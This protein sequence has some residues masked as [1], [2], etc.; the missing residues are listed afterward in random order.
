MHLYIKCI[1]LSKINKLTTLFI[2]GDFNSKLGQDWTN[3]NCSGHFGRG[4]RNKNGQQLVEFSETHELTATNTHFCHRASHR[5]TWTGHRKDATTGQTVP[6][7]NQIDFILVPKS[8]LSRVTNARSYSG[9]RLTSDHRL[10]V[11]SVTIP[12][13][14]KHTARRKLS[15]KMEKFNVFKL[16]SDKNER[17]KYQIELKNRI[18]SISTFSSVVEKWAALS[19]SI[20]ETARETIGT[21]KTRKTKKECP[22][23]E[24]LS[25]DQQKL[26]IQIANTTD[27]LAK[28]QLQKS[29]N[30]LL[31]QIHKRIETINDEEIERRTQNIESLKDSAQMF[32]SVRELTRNKS[33]PLVV[34]N[35]EGE[36]VAQ[37]EEAAEIVA[38][39]Y[40]SLFSSNQTPN[41][42]PNSTANLKKPLNR[43]IT[44][45]E[46]KEATNKLQNGRAVGP[47]GIPGELLKYGESAL[48][49]S[50]A[51]TFNQMFES[52][53]ELELGRGTLIVLPKP[54]KP[55]GLMSSLRPIVLLTTLRKTLSLITLRRIR[56]EVE[57]FLSKSQSGFRQYRSTSDA[58]WTHKWLIAIIMKTAKEIYILGLDMSRAFDT[59]DRQKL[60]NELR[61]IIDEDSWRMVKSLLENTNL[62][63][64]IGQ[65]LS[66][67]FNTDIGA[68][69]GDCLSPVLFVIYLELALRQIR[70]K[71]PRPEEDRAVP[72]EV[73]YADDTDFIS[74][75]KEVIAAIEPAAETIL[76]S[77]NLAVNREKT[78]HTKLNREETRERE[79]WRKTKKLGTLL[80]DYEEMKKRKQL[81][82][83]SFNNLWRIWSSKNNKI[84]LEKR[85]RLYNAYIIPVLTYNAC[86]WALTE[87]QLEELEAF[88]RK[89]LR[90]IIGI[91]YPRHISNSKLYEKCKAIELRNII[92]GARWRMSGHVLRMTDDTPAKC[93][94][95]HY[96]DTCN[97]S[98]GRPI[99]T[100]PTIINKDLEEAAARPHENYDQLGLPKKMSNIHDLRQL[101]TIANSRSKWKSIVENMHVPPPAKQIKQRPRRYEKQQ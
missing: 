59:I 35:S 1:N 41:L 60:L 99:T 5:T 36:I 7:Y 78:E 27:T 69:Q 4:R 32:Q 95:V 8:Q 80:G 97:K 17:I 20:K 18:E 23:L 42:D 73:L 21:I 11:T 10:V 31:I 50:I 100:M 62:Q 9:T 84:S 58:V 74:T 12:P 89:Q 86:T 75:S 24:K 64:R 44:I 19:E 28:S 54:G 2:A 22:L 65:T 48:H 71:C 94:T 3:T 66:K 67:P 51:D 43:P 68:P 14:H 72:N 34:K 70:A 76:K 39:H 92:R 79:V 63:A 25:V 85:L 98:R 52:G 30:K 57:S 38:K 15:P 53:D 91:E 45:E 77:W 83:V 55:P 56:P 61:E 82:T 101:E 88:R 46:V 93:A 81:A 37:Q 29:R 13:I 49:Q 40:V 96:F 90:S 16:A 47:D 87:T 33:K 6:I 26:R